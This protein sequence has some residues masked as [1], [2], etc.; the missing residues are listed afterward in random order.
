MKTIRKC[1]K[2]YR[3]QL[4]K[5]IGRKHIPYYNGYVDNL[6]R[7]PHYHKARNCFNDIQSGIKYKFDTELST[8]YNNCN[9]KYKRTGLKYYFIEENEIQ[10]NFNCFIFHIQ[11]KQTESF[12]IYLFFYYFYLILFY[13]F[14]IILCMLQIFTSGGKKMQHCSC[15]DANLLYLIC[16]MYISV[17]NIIY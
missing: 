11:M 17:V 3:L 15:I 1:V 10:Y 5:F 8:S 4:W 6:S 13:L 16:F 9:D 12:Y 7:F 14:Y 2:E